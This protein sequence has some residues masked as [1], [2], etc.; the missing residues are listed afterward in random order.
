MDPSNP[1]SKDEWSS[2]FQLNQLSYRNI[3][4]LSKFKKTVYEFYN[5]ERNYNKDLHHLY[6]K[7]KILNQTPSAKDNDLKNN[8]LEI[9]KIFVE[10]SN[11]LLLDV[12]QKLEQI[13]INTLLKNIYTEFDLERYERNLINHGQLIGEKTSIFFNA[14]KEI[15][16]KDDLIHKQKFQKQKIKKEVAQYTIDSIIKNLDDAETERLNL[17][18][19]IAEF[20][21]K[22]NELTTEKLNLEHAITELDQKNNELATALATKKNQFEEAQ[23]EQQKAEQEQEKKQAKFD[24]MNVSDSTYPATH[25]ARALVTISFGTAKRQRE[26]TDKK[27]T[28]L[29]KELEQMQS[30]LKAQQTEGDKLTTTHKQR[31]DS[32]IKEIE[33]DIIATKKMYKNSKSVSE[34]I[35][36]LQDKINANMVKGDECTDHWKSVHRCQQDQQCKSQSE[37]EGCDDQIHEKNECVR[38]LSLMEVKK[39][40][41]IALGS[42]FDWNSQTSF[43]YQRPMRYIILLAS[44]IEE[45]SKV[46]TGVQEEMNLDSCKTELLAFYELFKKTI[47]T[48]NKSAPEVK[49][50]NRSWSKWFTKN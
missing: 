49:K 14:A 31:I 47:D 35:T 4:D 50:A 33:Q 36:D 5:T 20:E 21:Q 1:E 19:A 7:L 48:Y 8:E 27:V 12:P 6:G 37:C 42:N 13:S 30:L 17:E 26:E 22:K 10:L 45:F 43:L 3:D 40:W 29:T 34:K 23:Q 46:D 44:I 39:N 32:I 18:H 16:P 15:C 24:A 2:L 28:N 25:R 38:T 9:V 11:Q 41:C